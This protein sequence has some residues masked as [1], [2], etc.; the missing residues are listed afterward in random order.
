M[1]SALRRY[2][3]VAILLHWASAF[4][5]LVLI[6]IG[7]TFARRGRLRP[8]PRGND[9]EAFFTTRWGIPQ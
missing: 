9:A 5:M 2:T 7:L 6:G 4:A 3:V 8:V 1:D